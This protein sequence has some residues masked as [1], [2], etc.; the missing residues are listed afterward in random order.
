MSGVKTSQNIPLTKHFFAHKQP[1]TRKSTIN[2]QKNPPNANS[3][4]E[5]DKPPKETET[6]MV[7]DG[8]KHP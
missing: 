1:S 5:V 4:M 6:E 7:T 3:N 2:E 8:D